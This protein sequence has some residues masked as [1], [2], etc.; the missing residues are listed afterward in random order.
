MRS[1]LPRILGAGLLGLVLLLTLAAPWVAVNDPA[2]QHRQHLLAPPMPVRIVDAQGRWTWPFVYPL[3]SVSLLERRFEE[4]RA[5]PMALRFFE[6]GRAVTATDVGRGPW[7][8]LGADRLGRDEW[9]RLV[10]GARLSLSVAAAA[11]GGSMA[12]G[13]L[14]GLVA[15]MT[16]GL[17]D[18]LLMRL[19]EL[20]LVLPVLYVVL[21]VRAALPL[22]L[23]PPTVFLLVTTALAALGWP[24]VARGVRAIVVRETALEY[25]L[26]ARA[27]GASP[28]RVA[29]L[30]VLPATLAFL[31]TL[32]LLLVPAAI[33]AETT[34]SFVGLG[35]EPDRP[36]WGTL[37]QEAS[38]VRLIADAP[39][40][41]SAAGAIVVVVLGINLLTLR[42][43]A[44]SI[45]Y[46]AAGFG[47]DDPPR[48]SSEERDGRGGER[49]AKPATLGQ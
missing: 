11:V 31:R 13:I 27:A 8:P 19:A 2:I 29:F 28:L 16:R 9:A 22:V 41:L 38:D 43:P 7:L 44:H 32:A 4:D 15:G 14:I 24:A 46:A 20:I 33:L 10:Y 17:V 26:A 37:L 45:E 47:N 12:I 36:S 18:A 23:E 40:L 5:Q 6:G 48:G 39:W 34:L 49:R 3:R 42:D 21:A 35:F 1:R 30:H 25:V